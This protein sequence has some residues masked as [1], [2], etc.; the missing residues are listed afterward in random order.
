MNLISTIL[1]SFTTEKTTMLTKD[2]IEKRLQRDEELMQR[3]SG[4]RETVR[5]RIYRYRKMLQGFKDLEKLQEEN[6]GD[7]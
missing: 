5:I 3:L 2:E 1:Q 6:L 7:A 4:E